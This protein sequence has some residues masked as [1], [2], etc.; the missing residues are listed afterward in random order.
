MVELVVLPHPAREKVVRL[1]A[2]W[3]ALPLI[4][5]GTLA[6]CASRS[7]SCAGFRSTRRSNKREHS[8]VL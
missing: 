7:A 3:T 2:N 6:S 8:D 4:S 5:R 1:A